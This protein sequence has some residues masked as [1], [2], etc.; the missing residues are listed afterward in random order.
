MLFKCVLILSLIVL[1]T[2]CDKEK[3]SKATNLEI[4][5]IENGYVGAISLTYNDLQ[6]TEEFTINFND[7]INNTTGAN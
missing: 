1:F 4:V 5:V 2:A 3:L 7:K 6:V